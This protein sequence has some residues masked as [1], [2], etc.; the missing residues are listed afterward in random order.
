MAIQRWTMQP[1]LALTNQSKDN[2]VKQKIGANYCTADL[3][4]E[5]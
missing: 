3:Q 1:K 2:N 5:N 4:A